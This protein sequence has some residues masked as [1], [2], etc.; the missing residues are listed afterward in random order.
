LNVITTKNSKIAALQIK[1]YLF[2]HRAGEKHNAHG[3]YVFAANPQNYPQTPRSS[4]HARF[5]LSPKK[6]ELSSFPDHSRLVLPDVRIASAGSA[7][8]WRATGDAPCG[9]DGPGSKPRVA[10][11]GT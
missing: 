7:W 1:I 9:R 8:V 4:L 10:A 2:V 5:F 11:L 3:F 6:K